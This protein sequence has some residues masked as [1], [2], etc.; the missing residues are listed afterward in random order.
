[1]RRPLGRPRRYPSPPQGGPGRKRVSH[2][3]VLVIAITAAVYGVFMARPAVT[4]L[5]LNATSQ[6]AAETESAVAATTVP[7]VKAA[8]ATPT[9]RPASESS[10]GGQNEAEATAAESEPAAEASSTP[11]ATPAAVADGPEEE[12]RTRSLGLTP[13]PTPSSVPTARPSVTPSPAATTTRNATA[14]LTATATPTPSCQPSESPA[15]CVYTVR[16]GDTLSAIAARFKLESKDVLGWAL[17]AESNKPDLTSVDDFIQPGQKLRIPVRSGVVHTVLLSE[18]VGDI[19]DLFDVTSASIIQANQLQ[20]KDLVSIGQVLLIPNPGKLP[21]PP[22]PEPAP[23]E[24]APLEPEPET[25]SE[26]AAPEPVL[27]PPPAPPSRPQSSFGFIWPIT[28]STNITSF[29]GPR[30]PLGVDLGLAHAPRSPII[31]VADGKVAFAG[32]DP[33]CSYGFYVIVDHENGFKT[34]YAH[35]SR[36][37]VRAGQRVEQG[38]V[39]GPS[40]STGYSTGYHL[41]FEV[42]RDGVRVNPLNY[43]P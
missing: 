29:F 13:V 10:S 4:A 19:A 26:P 43:L 27:P 21:A 28:A 42:H 40:G 39:L 35:L 12:Q 14:S 37:D 1:L 18:T 38:D 25:P 7:E 11:E 36:V 20:N 3:L 31:A 32:G 9:P 6:L 33:C 23:A 16:E 41:H 34:L 8:S 22:A 17:L 2:A 5:E 30:H 24:P 15:Y